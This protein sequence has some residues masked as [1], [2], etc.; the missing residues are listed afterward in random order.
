MTICRP[1]SSSKYPSSVLYT[2]LSLRTARWALTA[3]KT[4]VT[5]D[6]I[7]PN[8]S[9]LSNVPKCITSERDSGTQNTIAYLRHCS[10]LNLCLIFSP[11]PSFLA[12]PLLKD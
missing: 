8:F 1:K 4:M 10:A 11:V 5:F 12:S 2:I 9:T 7:L 6:V 3:K